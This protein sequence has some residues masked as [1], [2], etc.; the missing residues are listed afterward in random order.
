MG[1]MERADG[2]VVSWASGFKSCLCSSQVFRRAVSSRG[3]RAAPPWDPHAPCPSPL[4]LSRGT[5]WLW[6]LPYFHGYLFIPGRECW[7][8]EESTSFRGLHT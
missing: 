8:C 2:M 7:S 6:Y 1:V 5:V 3:L 4:V